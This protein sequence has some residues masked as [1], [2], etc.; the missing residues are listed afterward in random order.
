M[1]ITHMFLEGIVSGFPLTT[2]Q[3]C[4]SFFTGLPV[5]QLFTGCND[6]HLVFFSPE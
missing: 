1:Q 3:S 6:T 4:N 2:L 5:E